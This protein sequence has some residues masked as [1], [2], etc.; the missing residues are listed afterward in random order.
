[1]KYFFHKKA[2]LIKSMVLNIKSKIPFINKKNKDPFIY[3]FMNFNQDYLNISLEIN[4]TDYKSL[5]GQSLIYPRD[6][7]SDSDYYTDR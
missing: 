7:M 3:Q 6:D 2:I 1:M 4:S 5:E